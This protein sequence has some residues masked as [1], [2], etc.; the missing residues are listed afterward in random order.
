VTHLDGQD[1]HIQQTYQSCAH[2]VRYW[3]IWM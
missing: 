3:S 1:A 2:K